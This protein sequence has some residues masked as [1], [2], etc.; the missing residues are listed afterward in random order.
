MS[1]A[2]DPKAFSAV[3]HCIVAK[4]MDDAKTNLV[5]GVPLW[6]RAEAEGE[7][8]RHLGKPRAI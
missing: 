4:S 5:T 3:H 6:D 7:L 2:P 8:A 1:N